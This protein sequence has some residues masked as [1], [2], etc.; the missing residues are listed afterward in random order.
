MRLWSIDPGWLDRQGFLGLWRETVMAINVLSGKR[1]GYKN[2]PQLDR[3]KQTD[4]PMAYLS[5]YAWPLVFEGRGRDYNLNEK[6][7]VANWDSSLALP[8]TRGQVDYEIQHL[9]KKLE[10]RDIE[11]YN[12]LKRRTNCISVH[13]LFYV[14]ENNNIEE[15]ERAK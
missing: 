9:L 11:C 7:I 14:V 5:S 1:D 6:Y 4:N 15:W 10:V 8:V 3:F 13:P 12:Y 2:H